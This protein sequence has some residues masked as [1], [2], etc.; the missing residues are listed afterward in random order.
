MNVVMQT[1]AS[2]SAYRDL[3][4]AM[5]R[6][7]A[8]EDEI[9]RVSGHYH[10]ARGEEGV[11]CGTFRALAE[12]DVSL[13][14]YR[15]SIIASLSRGADPRQLIAGLL[16][17]VTGPT[18]GRQRGDFVGKFAPNHFGLFS[19]TL[20]PSIGYATGSALAAK[21]AGS[22]VATAVTF[23]DGTANS[24]L[25]YESLN[26]AAMYVLP[27]VFVCQHNQFAVS[28][29]SSR[30]IAGGSLSQRAGAFGMPAIEIDGN[31]AVAVHTAVSDALARARRGEGPTFIDALTYRISGHWTSDASPYRDQSVTEEWRQRDPID[32]LA[33]SLVADGLMSADDVEAMKAGADAE[34][35]AA[36][37]AAQDDP[38][39][40]ASVIDAAD[41]YASA[42]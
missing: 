34:A 30:A 4:L 19:G 40:D 21:L 11:I 23:G 32:R 22:D 10:P 20:G 18:R 27:V 3:L 12:T 41:A 7:R 6:G 17:K 24:G 31:D 35:R 36:M 8:V 38:W 33:A 37:A 13:P 26:M 14:H 15:G 25:L 16:G 28:M 42:E 2:N 5:M 29:P 9:Q 1:R 39:P